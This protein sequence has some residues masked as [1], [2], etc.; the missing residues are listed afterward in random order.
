MFAS[1]ACVLLGLGRDYPEKLDMFENWSYSQ[2]MSHK[3]VSKIYYVG[4][5]IP[6]YF[7]QEFPF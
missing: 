2:P 3:F 4:M 6:T 1:S 5:K 7:L